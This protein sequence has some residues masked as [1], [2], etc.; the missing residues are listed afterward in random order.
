MCRDWMEDALRA[1]T[2]LTSLTSS[3]QP[4]SRVE[5]VPEFEFMDAIMSKPVL[6]RADGR[7]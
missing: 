3:W 5:L 6:G 7:D 2:I 1:E 4:G